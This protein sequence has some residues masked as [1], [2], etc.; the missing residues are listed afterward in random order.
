MSMRFH[1]SRDGRLGRCKSCFLSRREELK[2]QR[3][4][5]SHASEDRQPTPVTTTIGLLLWVGIPSMF[6]YSMW[7]VWR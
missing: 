6:W 7:M 4:R 5:G 2:R 1:R 3:D